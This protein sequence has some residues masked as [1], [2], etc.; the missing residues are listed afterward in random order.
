MMW[1]VLYPSG[2]EG[3]EWWGKDP[4]EISVLIDI[5]INY[6]VRTTDLG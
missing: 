2:L 1:R 3:L 4:C 5:H 6:T